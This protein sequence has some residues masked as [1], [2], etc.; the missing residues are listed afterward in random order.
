[1][2]DSWESGRSIVSPLECGSLLRFGV[3]DTSVQ[4]D[5]RTTT[6]SN[7]SQHCGA[8]FQPAGAQLAADFEYA[9]ES[10]S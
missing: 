6:W 7:D 3:L 9:A 10:G 1:M 5:A 2:K 8:G 4:R